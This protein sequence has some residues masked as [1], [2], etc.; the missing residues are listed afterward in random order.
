[1]GSNPPSQDAEHWKQKYYDQLDQLEQ[2]EQQ[3]DGLE[4]VLKKTIS[5]LS[6]AAEGN[7]DQVDR[8]GFMIGA[9]HVA[10]P[11]LIRRR[12]TPPSATPLSTKTA[13]SGM[14]ET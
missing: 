14:V 7:H 9:L 11:A 2:K 12:T 4:S 8:F 10:K 6:L 13:T 3:W 5:R 1:M